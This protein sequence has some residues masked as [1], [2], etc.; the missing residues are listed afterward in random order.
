MGRKPKPAEVIPLNKQAIAD[1][2]TTLIARATAVTE[3]ALLDLEHNLRATQDLIES[4]EDYDDRLGSHQAF[5]TDKLSRLVSSIRQL[6]AHASKALKKLPPTERDKLV[7][8]YIKALPPDRLQRLYEE[9]GE[10]LGE[11]SLL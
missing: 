7:A 5:L 8:A 3:Q 11:T 9:I 10:L 6:D 4:G 1:G 2:S